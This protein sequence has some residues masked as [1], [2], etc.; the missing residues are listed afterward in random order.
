MSSSSSWES[1]KENAAPLQRGRNVKDLERAARRSRGGGLQVLKEKDETPRR[2]EE[3]EALVRPSESLDF[4]QLEGSEDPLVHWVEYIK[5]FQEAFP[6][7]MRG[8]FMLMERCTRALVKIPSYSNDD[9][10]I[11]VCAK[12]ADRAKTPGLIFRY[13]YGQKVGHKSATFWCAWAF[14]EEQEGDYKLAEQIYSK[15]LHKGIEPVKLLKDRYGQFKRRMSRI[16][17]NPSQDVDDEEEEGGRSRSALGGLSRDRVR[18]NDRGM[19]AP[20]SQPW[21]M[22]RYPLSTG[23]GAIRENLNAN[24]AS[25]SFAIYVEGGDESAPRSYLDQPIVEHKRVIEKEADRRKEN[26]LEAE[27]WN[28]RGGLNSTVARTSTTGSF[29]TSRSAHGRSSS[30]GPPAPFAVYVDEECVAQREKEDL[31]KQNQAI[32]HRKARDDRTFGDRSGER[33]A[34][35]LSRDPLRYVRDPSKFEEDSAVEKIQAERKETNSASENKKIK[36]KSPATINK[37]LLENKEGVE[38]CFEEERLNSKSFKIASGPNFNLLYLNK[39]D[40]SSQMDLDESDSFNISM[41]EASDSGSATKGCEPQEQ[42]AKPEARVLFQ[43][44]LSFEGSLNQTAISTAS[45]AINESDAVGV[46]TKKEEETINTKF[47][48]RELSMMFSSPAFGVDDSARKPELRVNDDSVHDGENAQNVSFGNVGD[49]LGQSMLDNSILNCDDEN[50][51]P[52]NPLARAN[53][54]PGF[55]KSALRELG[56]DGDAQRN[57]LSCRRQRPRLA[58]IP[59]QEN[60]MRGPETDLDEDPGFQIYEDAT[61]TGAVASVPFNIFQESGVNS[62]GKGKKESSLTKENSA[63]KGLINVQNFNKQLSDQKPAAT[64]TFAI[65]EG[66]DEEEEDSSA[67]A[68]QSDPYAKGDTATFS[69]LGDITAADEETKTEA[70]EQDQSCS[71]VQSEQGNTATLSV[72]NEIFHGANGEGDLQSISDEDQPAKS[73][74][75]GFSI[76]QDDGEEDT[77]VS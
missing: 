5:F 42:D 65:Y 19:I 12:Y 43:S 59:A 21:M 46:P 54:T 10:F 40:Q 67:D 33:M 41:R 23:R 20:S 8:Q 66:S 74:E 31:E 76:Y 1:V 69:L 72:F 28:E 16:W 7:D 6:S 27:R 68:R 15:A 52:R 47:A 45:S 29:L 38:Q 62:E 18:R 48:M 60:P 35:R 71:T 51:G 30:R 77:D 64:G 50:R 11:S 61:T 36:R 70:L 9:R 55:N 58:Q 37:Q 49:G 53:N 24:S 2:L 17:L 73:K 32:K 13:L 39:T 57:T 44:E 22:G 63:T 26:T 3:F 34:E 4:T 75:V 56:P 14:V 25:N